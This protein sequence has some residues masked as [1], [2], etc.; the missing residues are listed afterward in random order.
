[1]SVIVIKKEWSYSRLLT[2]KSLKILDVN[3]ASILG[4]KSLKI[5]LFQSAKILGQ[6]LEQSA[7]FDMG[8]VVEQ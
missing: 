2:V 5:P 6:E 3:S 8:V 7:D 1:M 4:I